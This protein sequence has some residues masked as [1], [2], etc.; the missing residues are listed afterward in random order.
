MLPIHALII[1]LSFFFLTIILLLYK[2]L[3][4]RDYKISLILKEKENIQIQKNSATEKLEVVKENHEKLSIEL[5]NKQTELINFALAIIQKN[6]F[7]DE[8]K[9]MVNEVKSITRETESL[10][11][12]NQ[13]SVSIN[14]H[15]AL[16]KNRKLFQMQ[17][18]EANRDFYFR[19]NNQFPQLT[20]KERK[21]SSYIRLNLSSK[22]IAS[23]L[24]INEKSVEINRYRLRKKL[25]LD[26]KTKLS[27]FILT[28]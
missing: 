20:E 11:K 9:Q 3:K 19:L 14:Q 28:I 10:A 15:I 5:D 12:L 7:L 16:D 26:S 18:E 17:L 25:G 4:K 24:N 2:A 8:L 23:L 1:L 6:T 21:L 13:L 22:E 27:D